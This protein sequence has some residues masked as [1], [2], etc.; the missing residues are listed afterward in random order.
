MINGTPEKNGSQKIK[1]IL[2]EIE[3]AVNNSLGILN[4]NALNLAQKY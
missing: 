3:S 2:N 4:N 1:N